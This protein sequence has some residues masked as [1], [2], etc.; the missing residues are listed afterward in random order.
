MRPIQVISASKAR[1]IRWL[2]PLGLVLAVAGCGNAGYYL[3]AVGGH[4]ELLQRSQ[5]IAEVVADPATPQPVRDKL[6]A[7][8]AIRDFATRELGLPDNQSY[9]KYADLNRPFVVWNVF[10]TPELS[11]QLKE[12]CFPVAGCVGYRGYYSRDEAQ[13]FAA[14]LREQGYE[15]FVRG[16][17]AYST[18]GWFDDPVLNTFIHYPE[19]ELARIIFHELAHQVAYAKGDMVFNESFATAVEQEGMRRWLERFGS[20]A[21]RAAYAAWERRREAFVALVLDYRGRLEALYRS[22]V[23]DDAKRRRKAELLDRMRRDYLELRQS[24]DGYS[25]YDHWF[26][27]DLG[28]A[29]LAS[30]AAYAQRVPQFAALLAQQGGALPP[31]YAAVRDLARLPKDKRVERL[32]ALQVRSATASGGW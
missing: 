10:A 1:W 14:G 22:P 25:G 8:S 32:D 13:A 27:Q 16:V 17:P 12:W 3:Q 21:Q 9:R 19:T 29:H 24:W 6:G 20:D 28:N 2:V 4:L 11:V 23:S 26:A 7:V 30:V 31:F 15:V 5:P 18:L